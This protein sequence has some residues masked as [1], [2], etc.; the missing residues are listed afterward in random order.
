LERV[1]IEGFTQYG[2]VIA[3]GAGGAS[4]VPFK[5]I[6]VFGSPNGSLIGIKVGSIGVYGGFIL[7]IDGGSFAERWDYATANC[8]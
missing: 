4:Y 8:N 2:I 1:L 6:E 7:S 3:T 5:D